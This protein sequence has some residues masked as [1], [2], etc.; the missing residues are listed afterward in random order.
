[1]T[2]HITPTIG[3]KVWLFI[4][5]GARRMQTLDVHVEDHDKPL[6]ASIAYVHPREAND[7]YTRVNVSYA[8]HLGVIRRATVPLRQPDDAYPDA[9]E[10]VEWMPFQ[11]GQAKAQAAP[12]EPVKKPKTIRAAMT[13]RD[14]RRMLAWLLIGIAMY[15]LSAL[16]GNDHPATQTVLYKLGHVTTLAWVGY[17]LARNALGRL[18]A[19]A[20]P[21]DRLARALLIAGVVVAGSLGR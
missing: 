21:T 14:Q 17:W 12:T 2:T 20:T 8:D 10:W 13:V 5:R 18:N 9:R 4:A 1:M 3:R 6:D 15:V 7:P 19:D 11:A 16:V